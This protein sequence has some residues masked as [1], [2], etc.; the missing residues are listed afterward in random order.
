MATTSWA[1]AI[2]NSLGVIKFPLNA[3]ASSSCSPSS[4][5]CVQEMAE[6]PSDYSKENALLATIGTFLN[7]KQPR[8][9]I[10]LD[11]TWTGQ[12]RPPKGYAT[13]PQRTE[14]WGKLEVQ[15]SGEPLMLRISDAALSEWCVEN[16]APEEHAGCSDENQTWREADY[17]H[18]RVW[19]RLAAQGRTCGIFRQPAQYR[20]IP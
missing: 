16:Q 15:V 10:K 8:N 18:D 3:D 13:H 20:R 14:Q 12:R 1:P 5:A 19:L 6:D 11:K 17:R 7:E 2:A 9:M 4:I